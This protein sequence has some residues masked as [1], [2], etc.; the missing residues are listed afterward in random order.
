MSS[1]QSGNQ[2][3]PSA[4]ASNEVASNCT[5]EVID[6]EAEDGVSL[7]AT[8]QVEVNG[9]VSEEIGFRTPRDHKI[10]R[11]RSCP[12]APRKPRPTSLGYKRKLTF[13]DAKREDVEAFFE[14]SKR[15]SFGNRSSP[16]SASTTKQ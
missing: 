4:A 10:P 13:E 16:A 14:R 7:A 5:P 9:Y 15:R 6:E 11:S 1:D 2:P 3:S 12:P 8:T